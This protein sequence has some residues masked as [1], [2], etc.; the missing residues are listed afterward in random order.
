MYADAEYN[1]NGRTFR[2]SMP[3]AVTVSAILTN[4]TH[5]EPSAILSRGSVTRRAHRDDERVPRRG[6]ATPRRAAPCRQGVRRAN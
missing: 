3:A 6:A 4:V 1:N 2:N 5:K